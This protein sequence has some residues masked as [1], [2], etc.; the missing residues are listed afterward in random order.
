MKIIDILKGIENKEYEEGTFFI[1]PLF[2]DMV[3]KD[4]GRGLSLYWV[5]SGEGVLTGNIQEAINN[6]IEFYMIVPQFKCAEDKK[7][8]D[9]QKIKNK[10]FTRNQKQIAG[11][12]NELIDVVN[13]ISRKM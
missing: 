5:E 4:D 8:K 9:I 13:E 3:L 12:I 2:C 10:R 11:K 6:D 7:Y 1:S